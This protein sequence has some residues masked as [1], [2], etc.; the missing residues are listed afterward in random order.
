MHTRKRE[1]VPT[2]KQRDAARANRNRAILERNLVLALLTRGQ[3]IYAHIMPA[4]SRMVPGTA[5]LCV[6]TDA[7]QLAWSIRGTELIDYFGHLSVMPC[8]WDG[9]T[10]K[11]R[12]ERLKGL[13]LQPHTPEAKRT[14]K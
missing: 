9:H 7:G 4:E 14:A 5:I 10:S 12:T 13:V 1:P 3:P 2:S 8:K 11:E 6:H